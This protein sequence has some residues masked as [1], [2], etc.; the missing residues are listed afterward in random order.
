MDSKR[1]PIR[2]LVVLLAIVL[3]VAAAASWNLL[4]NVK[5]PESKTAGTTGRWYQVYF[6]SPRYPDKAADHKGGMD[7]QLTS[8]IR[9]ATSSV[10]M[11]IYQLDLENV[12][13]ALVDVRKRGATVRVVTDID[14]LDD[15]KENPSFKR[16]QA[17][18]ITV[19]GGNQNAIMHDKYVVVDG[20]AVWTGSWN[21]T[22]NDTYRY[23]NNAISIGSVD[24]ARN[25]A[26]NFEKMWRDNQFG[27]RRR[28][29]GTTAALTIGGASVR[30][31]FAPEDKVADKIVA[32]LK[33]AE[34]TIDFMAFSFTDDQMGDE[35]VARAKA[36]VKVRGVFENTG[37]ETRYSEYGKLKAERVDV[38]QDG[39]P[40]LM[41]HK[42]FIIDEQTVVF[43][44][45]NFSGNAD[46]SNDENLL[47]VD[48]SSLAHQFT[49]EFERVY[50]QAKNP[51]AKK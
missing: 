42:V 31:Y 49:A 1:W 24:L 36:G 47:I 8:F 5:L 7:E 30:N 43:G 14:I 23:N 50:A 32:R 15:P 18:G 9:T 44:S 51:P 29:G 10:D 25:Y 34:K 17:A 2:I 46:E 28:A 4:S 22:E 37:S 38:L 16:L 6:T 39:N 26:A 21:F 40:Y 35:L 33:K 45:F 41:H 13:A 19:V 3:I 27:P 11:A 48:D 20:E 12:T